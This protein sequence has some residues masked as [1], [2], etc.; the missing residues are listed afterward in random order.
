MTKV[1]HD[2]LSEIRPDW[3]TKL[4]SR[5]IVPRTGGCTQFL[6]LYL[7]IA[8]S[9][10]E[11]SIDL[12]RISLHDVQWQLNKELRKLKLGED[13]EPLN[14]AETENVACC[15]TKPIHACLGVGGHRK[16]ISI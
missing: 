8:M 15:C 3:V 16:F 1:L 6:C 10:G 12:P 7:G 13:S 2:R 4:P 9:A 5:T 11:A 14:I